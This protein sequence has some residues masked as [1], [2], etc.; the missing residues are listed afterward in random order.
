MGFILFYVVTRLCTLLLDHQ[1]RA[2]AGELEFATGFR[3]AIRFRQL[4]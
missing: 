2:L 3:E 4:V 1:V